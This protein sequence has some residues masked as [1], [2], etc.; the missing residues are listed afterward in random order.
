[1]AKTKPF[2]KFTRYLGSN[3]KAVLVEALFKEKKTKKTSERSLLSQI[4]YR[5]FGSGQSKT[6]FK[7]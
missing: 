3:F 6:S 7:F 4:I 2:V 1:M 5:Q